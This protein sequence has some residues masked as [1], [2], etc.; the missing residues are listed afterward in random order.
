[1]LELLLSGGR[2]RSRGIL[3]IVFGIVALAYLGATLISLAV[4]FGAYAFVSGVFAIIAAFGS[5]GRGAVW[6]V[7]DGIWDRR[8]YCDVSCSRA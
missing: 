7:L 3:A 1:M 2:W 8:R 6:Y 5:R 4:M